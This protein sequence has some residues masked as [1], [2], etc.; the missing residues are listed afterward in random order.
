[1]TQQDAAKRRGTAR[2]ARWLSRA[3]L[4]VGGAVAGTAAAWVIG[5]ATASAD[6]ALPPQDSPATVSVTPVTDAAVAATDD[7]LGGLSG[8]VGGAGGAASQFDT[9]KPPA[10]AT[11]SDQQ[12]ARQATGAVHDFTR[13]AVLQPAQRLLSPLEQI[14]RQPQDAPRVLG[15]ALTPST[16]FLDLLRPQGA[17]IAAQGLPLGQSTDRTPAASAERND[18]V[19]E[20]APAAVDVPAVESH[21]DL[22]YPTVN[23]YGQ[24][25][26]HH[27]ARSEQVPSAPQRAPAAPSGLPFVPGGS[28]TGGHIDGPLLG[29]VPANGLTVREATGLRAARFASRHTPVQP[30]TQPGVTPD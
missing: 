24:Q 8:L 18:A 11:S 1:M 15:Q 9:G 5:S 26:R 7:V 21:A 30:G 20:T 23:S 3:L 29:G 6:T 27:A 22:A 10:A 13:N 17:L 12:A 4:T 2:A 14:S 25:D 19:A 16:G 28:A